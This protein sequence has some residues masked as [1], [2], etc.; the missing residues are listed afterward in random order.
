[1]R[2]RV[3][4]TIFFYGIWL[5]C[6]NGGSIL[7]SELLRPGPPDRA[8][9]A[10]QVRRDYESIYTRRLHDMDMRAHTETAHRP[11]FAFVSL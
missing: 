8:D 4:I 2:C 1:M 3:S 11:I 6:K 5:G 10:I 7:N 9:T